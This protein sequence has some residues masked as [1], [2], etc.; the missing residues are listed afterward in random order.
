MHFLTGPKRGT[1]IYGNWRC[2]FWVKFKTSKARWVPF[3][4]NAHIFVYL[5]STACWAEKFYDWYHS[6]AEMHSW[7]SS[8]SRGTKIIRSPLSL[9]YHIHLTCIVLNH[10]RT[11]YFNI[12]TVSVVITKYHQHVCAIFFIMKLVTFNWLLFSRRGEFPL[13]KN[14]VG[15]SC[16][17]K[18]FFNKRKKY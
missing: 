2:N 15:Y 6:E 10:S 16:R 12:F 18:A 13:K 11:F 17:K 5:E 14:C 4:R 9:N 7:K 3:P 1:P 8:V